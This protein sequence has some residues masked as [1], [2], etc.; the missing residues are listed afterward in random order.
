MTISV[1]DFVRSHEGECID[2]DGMFGCQCVD[3][4]DAWCK[5]NNV[6]LFAG[7]AIAAAGPVNPSTTWVPN[8]PQD[9][10]Q[11]P[12]AGAVV[13]WG[14]TISEFGHIAIVVQA[15]AG[16]PN[17]ESLDQNWNNFNLEHGSPAA[18]VTHPYDGVRGWHVFK[19]GPDES[20]PDDSVVPSA[21]VEGRIWRNA[22][23]YNW[24]DLAPLQ[25]TDETGATR[26]M[27]R[28]TE[29]KRAGGVWYDRIASNDGSP[30]GWA[31]HDD[32]ID[33]GGFDPTHFRP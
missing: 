2:P 19:G 20:G 8:N 28:W 23:W 18:L 33:D 15:N 4:A 29:A 25:T 3:L 22:R 21:P 12:P 30:G 14:A 6:P 9:L 17:F 10:N 1:Q 13:V 11:V 24:S 7:N 32:D 27:V 16:A 5:A 31:L 26:A